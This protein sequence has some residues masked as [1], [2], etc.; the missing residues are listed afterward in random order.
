MQITAI[1]MSNSK[2]YRQMPEPSFDSRYD[3]VI[4]GAGIAGLTL[5]RQLLMY[6]DKM[7]LLLEKRPHIPPERQKVGESNVQV[8]GYYLSKILDMEEHLLREHFLKYNLRFYW[9]T[10]G[11]PN[12]GYE[13]YSQ[14]YI[15][16]LSNVC[17]YQ[18]DRNKIE[19]ELLKVNLQ[20][21][22]FCFQ[23]NVSNL[24]VSLS[25]ASAP[26]AVTF[27]TEGRKVELQATWVVDTTG[28]A[29]FLARRL[30]LTKPNPIR[31]G[32]VFFWV[33]GLLNI[34]KLTE[35]SR[36]QSLL[37]KNRR[38]LGHIPAWLG[39]NHFCGEG[40]WFWVIPLQGKTSLGL[41]YDRAKVNEDEVNSPEKVIAWVCKR[42]PLFQRDLSKLKIVDEGMIR[43]F[44]YDCK[45]TIS[46][47]RWALA[48]EAGRFTDPLYSPGGDLIALYNTLI[49]DAI[50]TQEEGVLAIK[51]R[52]YELLMWGLYEAYV[53]S[54]AVSYEVLGDHEC[55][56]MK[57]GW[58]LTIY[59]TFYVFPFVNQLFTDTAFVV[60]YLDLFAK[61]GALN[62]SV[63]G[64]ITAYYRWKKDQPVAPRE[65]DLFDFTGLEP[66]KKSEEL[67]YKVGLSARECIKTLRHSMANIQNLARF[68]AVYIYS[69][70]LNDEELLTNKQFVES[71]KIASLNFDP[72]AMAQ[73][74]R[75]LDPTRDPSLA[76]L[77]AEFIRQ[78]RTSR[79]MDN[80]KKTSSS[81]I[82]ASAG[83]D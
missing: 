25:T 39:T 58:E 62:N 18:L 81:T 41:V 53:P 20:D 65:P 19:G 22:K 37:H 71:V 76:K 21:P 52:L 27:E 69:V 73:E 5:A 2:E 30:E 57:Y 40:Y 45:Q 66:L 36:T 14:S 43:D 51:S 3:V 70:V 50:L 46:A 63:Q 6:S 33:D 31:H 16:L 54:Y 9:P 7:V 47:E 49:T 80:S 28:R 15:R 74:C 42:H 48:G 44:S 68:I 17:C 79:P 75:Y 24:D 67:F 1:S 77:G 13:Q 35:L 32:S 60:P 55:F 83:S 10:P 8:Q 11:Q 34:E 72:E 26:H 82:Y 29:K 4:L 56:V 64:F 78:F 61:L 12:T 38:K 23:A 59:F